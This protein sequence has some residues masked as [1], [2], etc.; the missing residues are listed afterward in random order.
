[1]LELQEQGVKDAKA[2]KGGWAEWLLGKNPTEKA[3]R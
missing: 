2:L 3:D 1:M